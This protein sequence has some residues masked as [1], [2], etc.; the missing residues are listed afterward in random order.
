LLQKKTILF[1][2]PSGTPLHLYIFLTDP[3]GKDPARVLV[4]NITSYKHNKQDRTVILDEN[5]HS[6]IT[7]ESIVSF[8]YAK[9]IRVDIAE[10]MIADQRI[11]FKEDISNELY[12]VIIEG[13]LQSKRTPGDVK[14]FC[15]TYIITP[16]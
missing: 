5:S 10:K 16:P 8:D 15:R 3:I 2:F 14:K 13:L 6:F 4:V 12:Q 9:I 1:A 11:E 7:H